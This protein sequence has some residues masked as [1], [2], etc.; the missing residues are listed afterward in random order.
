MPGVRQVCRYRRA[1]SASR[2]WL[3]NG[4]IRNLGERDQKVAVEPIA[5]SRHGDHYFV[6]FAVAQYVSEHEDGLVKATG[7]DHPIIPGKLKD[8]LTGADRSRFHQQEFEYPRLG[9]G[10]C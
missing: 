10:K 8:G 4:I 2:R 1:G 7:G 6:I 9:A 5:A 3:L